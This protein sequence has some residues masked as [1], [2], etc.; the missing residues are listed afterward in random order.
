[1]S[2]LNFLLFI[3]KFLR[4]FII[5]LS[6]LLSNNYKNTSILYKSKN[7]IVIDKAYDLK[8]NSNNKNEVKW[9]LTNKVA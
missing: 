1:M 8:I 3:S 6:G 4:N 5:N 7:F 9:A 2:H